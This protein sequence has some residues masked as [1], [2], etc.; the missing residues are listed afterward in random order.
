MIRI[1]LI[2]VVIALMLRAAGMLAAWMVFFTETPKEAIATRFPNGWENLP[3]VEYKKSEPPPEWLSS[4]PQVSDDEFMASIAAIERR[5]PQ[6]RPPQPA[7]AVL[8]DTQIASMKQR[9]RLTADQEPYW[10]PVEASLRLLAWDRRPGSRP[11]LDPTSL[12]QFMEAAG[13]FIS[14]LSTRQ[15]NELQALVHIVGLKLERPSQ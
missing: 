4:V 3:V 14:T 15:R 12:G 5:R 9:L 7:D 2:G 6:P 8:S 1:L 11:R 10:Q 13:L